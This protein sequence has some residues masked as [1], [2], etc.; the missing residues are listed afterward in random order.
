MDDANPLCGWDLGPV[1]ECGQRHG[2][3]RGN[4]F[5]CL[6]FYLKEQFQKF[7]MRAKNF[8]LD[9]TVAIRCKGTE[10]GDG[11]WLRTEF[12]KSAFR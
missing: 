8:R 4:A 2:A 7:A 3:T 6:F 12:S 5:G 9:L 1:F 11:Q 10:P